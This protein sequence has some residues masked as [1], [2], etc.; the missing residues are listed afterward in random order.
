MNAEK[1]LKEQI[2]EECKDKDDKEYYDV[3]DVYDV[4]CD[5]GTYGDK[6]LVPKSKMMNV[7]NKGE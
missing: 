4:D 5:D 1:T 7:K 2:Q 6:I 3:Y